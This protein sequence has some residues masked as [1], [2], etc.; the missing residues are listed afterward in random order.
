MLQLPQGSG[1]RLLLHTLRGGRVPPGAFTCRPPWGGGWGGQTP[2]APRSPHPCSFYSYKSFETGV[3]PNVAL[4]PPAQQKVV[5]SPP[6]A[7]VVSRAPEPLATCIQPRKRKLAVDT[8][9]APETPAPVAAPEDGKDSEAEVEVD[10]RE[11]C[12]CES[13]S[14]PAPGH[15][16]AARRC[17]ERSANVR[18]PS[19]PCVRSHLLPVLPLLP[20]P[21]LIQLR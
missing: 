20:V 6:C 14:L 10:S 9:G 5:S 16:R 4:A 15:R 3:A 17:G 12:T 19:R 7:T 11:E 18:F 21:Y 1:S 13:G 8:P 2:V